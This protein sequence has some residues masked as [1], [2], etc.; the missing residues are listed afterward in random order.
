MAGH[1]RLV[2]GALAGAGAGAVLLVC[3][4]AAAL[5]RQAKVR[6]TDPGTASFV[7]P[8]GVSSVHIEAIGGRGGAAQLPGTALGGF[9]DDV[10]GDLAVTPGAA[11]T[12]SVGLGAGAAGIGAGAGG[13]AS[14]VGRSTTPPM[15]PMLVAGGGGGAGA[16]SGGG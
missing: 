1:G 9:G 4:P 2:R 13:G 11:L 6:F 7:V 3:G 14:L 5:A 12:V 8:V 15:P 16:G 10:A